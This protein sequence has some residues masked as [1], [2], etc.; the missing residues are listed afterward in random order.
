[1][2]HE[3]EHEHEHEGTQP[4]IKFNDLFT[5]NNKK[6]RFVN[7]EKAYQGI[8]MQPQAR[9]PKEPSTNPAN[10]CKGV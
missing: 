3:H 9:P 10:I 7:A 5:I 8:G 6:E 4:P 1:M 2:Q